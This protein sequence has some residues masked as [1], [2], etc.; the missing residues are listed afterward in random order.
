MSEPRI[1]ALGGGHGLAASLSALRRLT[2]ELTAIVTVADNG[3]SSGR[4]RDEFG[5]LPPGDLR[6]ALAALC[7]DDRWGQTWARVLQHRFS[8][9]GELDG[10]SLGNLLIVSLWDLLGDHV[11]GLD[12]VAGLLGARGRVLPMSTT[13]IDITG[14]VNDP[15]APGGVREVRGQVSVATTAGLRDVSLDPHDPPA[16]PEAVAAIEEADLVVLGP[17]SWFTSVLPHLLVPDLRAALSSTGARTVIT[18]NLV[19]QPG[20]TEGYAPEDHLAVLRRHAPELSIDTVIAD[21]TATPDVRR[22]EDATRQWGGQL[23]LVD[24]RDPYLPGVH[25]PAKLAAAYARVL[26]AT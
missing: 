5:V 10:H 22:L 7:G 11:L 1:V 26:E 19:A 3:G 25:D 24:V 14:R 2:T 8:S 12:W 16:C 23:A 21:P 6:M 15:S 17:G 18:M 20:E 13:A 4:L 9:G